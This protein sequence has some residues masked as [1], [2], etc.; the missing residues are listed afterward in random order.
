MGPKAT[1][2]KAARMMKLGRKRM[3]AGACL[4]VLSRA[5]DCEVWGRAGRGVGAGE[6][7]MAG[8]WLGG[9]GPGGGEGVKEGRR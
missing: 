8:A 5:P 9:R 1:P 7:G 6:E 4:N 3:A 2:N